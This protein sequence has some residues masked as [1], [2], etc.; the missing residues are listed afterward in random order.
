MEDK[1]RLL[2]D[3]IIIELGL[4]I[5]DIEYVKEGSNNYLRIY[6]D[7]ANGIDINEIVIASQKIGALFDLDDPISDEYMLEVSSPGAEKPLRTFEEISNAI[8]Q[9]IAIT[10]INP[11]KGVDSIQGDLVSVENQNLS[12]NYQVKTVKKSIVI[13]YSNVKKARLAIKF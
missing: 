10:L 8:N 11:I 12:L 9:H 4:S 2:I 1:I 5:Y 6:L 3:P 7:K 13:P